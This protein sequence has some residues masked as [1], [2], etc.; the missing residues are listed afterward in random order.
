MKKY[1][2]VLV[3]LL[4][5][6]SCK[7]ESAIEENTAKNELAEE[8]A[9]LKTKAEKVVVKEFGFELD[10]F[11]VK[12]DTV[13]RGDSFGELMISHKVDYPKIAKISQDFK[14][15]FDVRKIRV[16]NPYMI[17]QSKDTTETA[18]IFIYENDAINYTVVDLRDSVNAYKEKRDVKYVEREASGVIETSLSDAILA[19]GIDYAITHN[20]ANVYAWTIDFNRLQK[21]DKFK[22]IYQEK[23]INDSIYAGS[24]PIESAYFEHNGK[25]IYAF[26]YENDSLKSLMDYFDQ[27]ANSLRRTFL[28]MPVEFGRLSSKFNLKRRIRFYGNRIRPHR[29]TD[30]AAPVGTPILATAD[31]TVTESTRRG[32]NGK[33]VKVRHNGTYSTQYLHMKK[34]NVKRG[35]FVRQGDVI[36]WIGMTGNTSGPHVCYRFWRNGKEVDPL[37][38]ELPQA[39]PLAEGLRPAYFKTIAPKKKQLDCIIY[40]E[41][42]AAEDSE[43]LLTLNQ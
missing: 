24:G 34:Q 17:L 10:K 3:A 25:P 31:G 30:Y 4:V 35:D 11:K 41:I 38:E 37:R 33:Y 29:G 28:R 13:R 26:A 19:Q 7:D 21:G 6:V 16:G 15:T 36:G 2:A 23:Y 14:D 20:L 22:V 42:P 32:G 5:I 43:D 27:D 1:I 40:P 9:Q 8:A 39:E 12:L 18:Q